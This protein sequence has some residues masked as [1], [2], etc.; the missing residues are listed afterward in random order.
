MR[1]MQMS[2]SL[3]P[4]HIVDLDCVN[5]V[6]FETI[7]GADTI[8]IRFGNKE[9]KYS[10]V[11]AVAANNHFAAMLMLWVEKSDEWTDIKDVS[12]LLTQTTERKLVEKFKENNSLFVTKPRKEM[13]DFKLIEVESS[14]ESE[15]QETWK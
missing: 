8:I 13:I 7:Q 9:V 15:E 1:L 6:D 11:D 2:K 12:L 4:C 14:E 5:G 10:F 3:Q